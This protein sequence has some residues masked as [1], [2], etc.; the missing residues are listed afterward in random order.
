[1]GLLN[2]AFEFISRIKFT[3]VPNLFISKDDLF[4]LTFDDNWIYSK[5][6]N[7]FYSFHNLKDDLKGGLQFSFTWNVNPP[8]SMKEK[9]AVLH[10]IHSNESE[11]IETQTTVIYDLHAINYR[12][13]YADSNMIFSYWYIYHQKILIVITFMIFEDE[14][15][16]VQVRWLIRVTN[17]IN[18]LKL[19]LGKFQTTRMR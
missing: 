2:K 18:S 19:N 12:K 7:S 15:D 17:I 10:F 1:M 4:R 6:G 8:E 5:K 13:Q 3:N 14:P 11:T 9:E 16:D